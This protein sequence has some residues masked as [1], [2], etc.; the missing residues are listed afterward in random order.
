VNTP[1]RFAA[2]VTLA[3]AAPALAYIPPATTVLRETVERR[4]ET[5]PASVEARGSIQ[6][7]DAA[8]IP[9]TLWMKAPGRCRLEIALPGASIAERPMV[10]VRNGRIASARAM[11]SAPAAVAIAEAACALLAGPRGA[12]S[13]RGYAQALAQRGVAVGSVSL[14]HLGPRI[15]W[16]LGG[17]ARGTQ[18][19]AWIDKQERRPLRLIAELGGARRDVRLLGW[20]DE[21]KAAFPRVF[22]V[23]AGD[24]VEARLTV[25]RVI[26]N[27]RVPDSM[28]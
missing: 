5:Q 14:G 4:D 25:S 26:P 22:E 24:S 11:E 3:L 20:L 23:H 10:V 28:F 8:P 19:Q 16:V 15:A 7:G 13:D 1:R 9:T 21:P 12:D 18:P 27:P 2:L 17:P 6:L